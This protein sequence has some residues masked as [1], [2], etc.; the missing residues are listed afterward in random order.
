[1]SNE[2]KVWLANAIKEEIRKDFQLI[3]LSGNLA[4]TIEIEVVNQSTIRIKVPAKTYNIYLYQKKGVIVYNNKGSYA[5][6]VDINGGFSGV[7]QNFLER[8]VMAAIERFIAQF[9]Y[10]KGAEF[11]A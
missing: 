5:S 6:D 3:H 7:H 11:F 4:N 10:T 2:Q 8:A 1:M 9:G